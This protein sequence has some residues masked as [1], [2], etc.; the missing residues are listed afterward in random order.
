MTRTQQHNTAASLAGRLYP[1][2]ALVV[3][4][5]MIGCG[6]PFEAT[7]KGQVALD[8]EPLGTGTVTFSPMA[9]DGSSAYARVTDSG[10]YRLQTGREFGLP[11]GEYRV[12]VVARDRPEVLHT[13]DGGP[14]PPGRMLTP[15]W[16][17]STETSGLQ[18]TVERGSNTI[19]LELSSEPPAGWK[20]KRRRR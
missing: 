15:A 20:S 17:R 18:F 2:A 6:G 1:L 3:S 12:T 14:P 16:Y 13:A 19:D 8:G 5:G 7:V 4:T 9:A 11:A 10:R